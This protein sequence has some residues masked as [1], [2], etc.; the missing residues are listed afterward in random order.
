MRAWK[1][2]TKSSPCQVC[3]HAGW[4]TFTVDGAVMCQYAEG[5]DVPGW[6]KI[7]PR[8]PL[9]SGTIYRRD[10]DPLPDGFRLSS[11]ELEIKQKED[12]RAKRKLIAAAKALWS[13]G[14]E[15]APDAIRY[16]EGR[17]IRIADLPGAALPRA[18]RCTGH[19]RDQVKVA[20][21]DDQYVQTEGPVLLGACVD[22]QGRFCA[23]QRIF[24][25]AETAGKRRHTPPIECKLAK[26]PL[27]G[28]AVRLQ[29]E[30]PRGVLIVTEGIETGLAVLAATKLTVWA[31][32]STSGMMNLELPLADATRGGPLHTVIFAADLDRVDP[33][34]NVRPGTHAAERGAQNLAR[35]YPHLRIGIMMPGSVCAPDLVDEQGEIKTGKGVDWLD[36]YTQA[37]AESVKA[38]AEKA[39]TAARAVSSGGGR[40]SVPTELVST[41]DGGRPMI[42]DNLLERA[43]LVLRQRFAPPVMHAGR[44]WK[45][46]RWNNCWWR[47]DGVKYVLLD[48]EALAADLRPWLNKFWHMK[49]GIPVPLNPSEKSVHEVIANLQTDTKVIADGMPYWIR[50]DISAD[51]EPLFEQYRPWERVVDVD[52]G[53][54]ESYPDPMEM[55]S[56]ANGL[57]DINKWIDGEV[58]LIPHTEL[59]FSS[60]ALPFACPVERLKEV[61]SDPEALDAAIADLC[62]VWM[63]FLGL[64]SGGD[65]GWEQLLCQFFGYCLTPWT[66]YEIV[67]VM[68]GASR[69]GKGTILQALVSLLGDANVAASDINLLTDR[70]HL[71]TLVGKTLAVMPDADVGRNTDAVRAAETLKKISGG[72]PVYVD[73]KN[74]DALAAVRLYC[75]ILIMCN[76]MPSLPDPS[77]AIANRFRVLEFEESFA[78][79]EDL[80][81]KDPAIMRA[82]AVGRMLWALKGLR[83]LAKRQKFE[84]PKAGEELL[85]EYRDWSD[86]LRSFYQECLAKEDD[87]FTFTDD[88]YAVW[89]K[90][91][92]KNGKDHN[93]RQ[94]FMLQLRAACPWI[95]REQ[96][97]RRWG[98]KRISIANDLSDPYLPGDG[99]IPGPPT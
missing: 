18:I 19:R 99:L 2:T 50:P 20:D 91:C 79:K 84:Q 41:D 75:K 55:I 95:K 80:R 1:R 81:F 53:D 63:E 31:A 64:V 24:L 22:H 17:G 87:G 51:G 36:V 60:T 7:N 58:R 68:S 3:G 35:K 32:I 11:A 88:L 46:R 39:I 67:L 62:P 72:D 16:V 34:R 14:V 29:R 48:D 76:R 45:L 33:R 23:V 27:T 15:N 92:A 54:G 98:Y 8:V 89:K 47:H 9:K 49:R 73:R 78:G 97:Q 28:A 5:A 40:D 90:W 93:S 82:E 85:D 56:F 26:G 43:R 94:W 86:P 10:G 57:F 21:T 70:F 30:Y 6:R 4:C 69:G 96:R 66:K 83:I 13:E 71:H 77:G 61:S 38:A 52:A 42:P 44:G 12:E 37:G 59:L 74:V 65:P 25:D